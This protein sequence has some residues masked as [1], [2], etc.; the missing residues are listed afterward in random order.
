MGVVGIDAA[1]GS[2]LIGGKKVFPI[3]LSNGPPPSSVAPSGR[4]G[5]AEVA[6]AG[7]GFLRTGTGNW[8]S[9]FVAGQI[10]NERKLLD[11]AA[12]HG[13]QCW[14]WLGRLPN[15]PTTTGSTTER[16]LTQVV[17]ALKGHPAL[18][19]R[20]VRCAEWAQ[21]PGASLRCGLAALGDDVEAALVVL[22]DGPAL[23]PRA[24][25]RVLEHRGDAPV[26]AASYDGTRDHPAV[27]SRAVW[28]RVPDEGARA[29]DAAL[30]ACDDLEPP[31][32]FDYPPGSEVKS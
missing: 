5:L 28:D 29:L 16:L 7:V 26:V 8:T 27:L 6:A 25:E 3:I 21:G 31:G 30:V 24:V 32:D 18:G 10:Q 14:T 13:L 12:A 11:A 20:V 4:N 23:D 9:E 2:L 22:A 19:V 17:N 15:L 1:T